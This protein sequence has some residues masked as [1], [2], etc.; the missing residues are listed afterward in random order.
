[1]I[2]AC[3]TETQTCD[4]VIVGAHTVEQH[5]SILIALFN[6]HV[7]EHGFTQRFFKPLFVWIDS[8]TCILKITQRGSTGSCA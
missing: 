7:F 1:M 4:D 5:V 2:R 8:K 3:L 6:E